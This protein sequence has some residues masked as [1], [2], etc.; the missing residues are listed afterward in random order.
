[1]EA[2]EKRHIL[3]GGLILVT[4]GVLIILHKMAIFA[5]DKSWPLLLIVIAVGTL[6]QRFKDLGGWIIGAV[7][8]VFLLRENMALSMNELAT[9]LLPILLILVGVNI[10]VKQRKHRS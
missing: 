2:K 10:I 8:L 5:F 7:G 3:T 6:A 4:L 9:Y 1:M